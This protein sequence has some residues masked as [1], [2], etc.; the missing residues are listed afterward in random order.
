MRKIFLSWKHKQ[1]KDCSAIH[2]C[3][4]FLHRYTKSKRYN[5]HFFLKNSQNM[6][7][8]ILIKKIS[9]KNIGVLVTFRIHWKNDDSI[10]HAV[11]ESFEHFPS[12]IIF[13]FPVY[14]EAFQVL[15][16]AIHLFKDWKRR[17]FLST[18]GEAGRIKKAVRYQ[19]YKIYFTSPYHNKNK[20]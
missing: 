6:R 15:F 4:P 13:H 18:K 11:L 2:H 1:I 20:L 3:F 17:R 12:P 10:V 7:L 19:G 16:Y 5:F 14:G 9:F 8:V